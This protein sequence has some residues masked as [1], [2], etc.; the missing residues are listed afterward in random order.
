MGIASTFR[1]GH[2][3]SVVEQHKKGIAVQFAQRDAGYLMEAVVLLEEENQV[4]EGSDGSGGPRLN[5][6][7]D[8]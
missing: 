2:D 4:N 7:S 1:G 3:H 6:E 5:R 8:N